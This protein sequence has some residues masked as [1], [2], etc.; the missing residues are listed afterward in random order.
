MAFD[1]ERDLPDVAPE[2]NP[3][4]WCERCQQEHRKYTFTRADWHAVRDDAVQKLAA[5]IDAEVLAAVM[6]GELEPPDHLK[7]S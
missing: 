2:D 5:A 7:A 3:V 4:V 6:N 1:P